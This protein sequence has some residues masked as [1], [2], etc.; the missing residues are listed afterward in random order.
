MNGKN[1]SKSLWL[2]SLVFDQGFEV[3]FRDDHVH[4]EL[5]KDFK[6]TPETQIKFWE[7]VAEAC[8]NYDSRRVLVQG[9]VPAGERDAVEVIESG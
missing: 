5:S 6:I 4:V 3:Q 9:F 2:S 7:V 1:S 8:E